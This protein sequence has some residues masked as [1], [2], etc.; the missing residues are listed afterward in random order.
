MEAGEQLEKH[1]GEKIIHKYNL[2]YYDVAHAPKS[3]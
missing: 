2:F 3:H 1:K